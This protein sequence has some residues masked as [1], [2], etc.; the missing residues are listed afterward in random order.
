MLT[1]VGAE[2]TPDGTPVAAP[3]RVGPQSAAL[4][5]SSETVIPMPLSELIA[6]ERAIVLYQSD[7]AMD[8]VVACGNVG[9]LLSGQM[10]GMTMPGDELAVWLGEEAGSGLSGVALLEA[11]GR[12]TVDRVY[13]GEGLGG[14]ASVAAEDRHAEATPTT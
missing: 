4:V 8:R 5:A 13:L 3:E 6:D 9:G 7:E 1:G 2:A 12:A 14:R 11:A 10:P